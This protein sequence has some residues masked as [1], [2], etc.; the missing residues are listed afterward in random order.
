MVKADARRDY[1]AGL[2]IE[3]NAE[4]E[5]RKRRFKKLGKMN[6]QGKDSAYAK[7]SSQEPSQG[8]E[9]ECVSK[10]QA[11]QAAHVILSDSQ[12][13]LK[14]D[15]DRLRAGYGKNYGPTQGNLRWTP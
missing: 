6:V 9:E 15:T 10:F 7:F 2:G 14:Y 1:Y 13:R 4:A 11:I 3:P 5:E 8:R 12:K